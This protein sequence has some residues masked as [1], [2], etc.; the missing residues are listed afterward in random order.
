MV[1]KTTLQRYPKVG[2]PNP[3]VR[4]GLVSLSSR[5]TRWVDLGEPHEYI[6]FMAWT[7]DGSALTVQ[8]LNR[9]QNRLRLYRV[10]PVTARGEV[11]IEEKRETWVEAYEPPR[12]LSASGDFLWLSERT[13]FRHLYVASERGTKIRALTHGD[14][15][16][17]APGFGGRAVAVDEDGRGIYFVTTEPSPIERHVAWVPIA[18]GEARRL[19]REPGWHSLHASADGAYWVD[20]WSSEAIPVRIDLRARD[21]GEV[22]RLAEVSPVDFAPY[23]FGRREPMTIR[24]ED[25]VT[26]HAS[27]LKPA[28]FDPAR[29]YPVV[30]QVYGEP[31][32]QMVTRNWVSEWEMVLVNNG[33]LVFAFDGRGTPGRGRAWVDPTYGDQAT[34]PVEDW[35]RA[36]A[37]LKSLPYVDGARL[38]VWGWSGGGTMTLNL[39]FRAPGLFQAGAAVAPVADRRLYDSV[40]TERYLGVLPADEEAYRKSSPLEAAKDLQGKLLIAHGISDDNVHVQNTYNLAHRSD[41]RR[42]AVRAVPLPPEGPRY[43]GERRAA[44]SLQPDP[45]LLPRGARDRGAASRISSTALERDARESKE[46]PEG[47][48]DPPYL[49]SSGTHGCGTAGPV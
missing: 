37:Y 1:P 42:Q 34:L 49:C 15:D 5:E 24:S 28:D 16:V 43:R 30:A 27:I 46:Y 9:R 13:G 21:G 47:D 14:W 26:F 3:S 48:R 12:F 19:T 32:C 4:L 36:V 11:L 2:T 20:R 17:E 40:Y 38:G 44:P 6:L 45:R 33:F 25:G 23:H 22:A 39:M 31:C 18:G 10:D 7:P 41:A 29:R 35:K 8:T